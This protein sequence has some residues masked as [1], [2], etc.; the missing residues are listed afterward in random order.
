MP[1]SCTLACRGKPVAVPLYRV[2]PDD[3]VEV[4]PT[5]FS[6]ERIRERDDL[7]RL[8][9]KRVE[10]LG[11]DLLVVAE[12][13]AL[14]QDSR[15]RI[16]LLAVD[17]R[18]Q[19]V[20]VELKR[21]DDG[22]HMELQALRY[23]AMVSTMSFD[24]LVAAYAHYNEVDET[25]ARARLDEWT[26]EADAPGQLTNTVRLVLMSADFSTEVTGTVLWLSEQ[27]GMDISCWRLRPYRLGTQL[28]LDLT[29]IIPLPEAADFQVQQRRKGVTAAAARVSEQGRDFTKYDVILADRRL[30]PL[31]KQGAV[32]TAV[33]ELYEA[34]VPLAAL[35]AA[36]L[37]NRWRVVHP[38]DGESLEA[39]FRR[40]HPARGGGWWF[41]LDLRDDQGA[42]VMPRVG[43]RRVEALLSALTQAAEASG[44]RFTWSRSDDAATVEQARTAMP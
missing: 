22:G 1:S 32:K 35:R 15:R 36:A 40:E 25:D 37:G 29:Q 13:Y 33:R 7:Q 26:E 30:G 21:T 20:V 27:Y 18:A 42:W 8:L 39:A 24:D 14:F 6:A 43:G 31:S 41:D 3:L 34:R 28:L 38:R 44:V 12:E 10:V 23:A 17:R 16:D 19:L 11:E 5:S 2:E 9:R 4:A